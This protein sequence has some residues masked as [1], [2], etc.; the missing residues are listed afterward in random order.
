[1][2]FGTAFI[3]QMIALIIWQ[4]IALI[5][6]Q[7]IILIIWQMIEL[8][9]WQMKRGRWTKGSGGSFPKTLVPLDA[10]D[11]PLQYKQ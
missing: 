9:I 3:W 8:I 6:W 11:H 4:M 2:A 5:I 1:M 7:M 10:D